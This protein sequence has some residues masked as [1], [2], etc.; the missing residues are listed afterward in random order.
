MRFR[1]DPLAA[2]G[3]SVVPPIAPVITGGGSSSSNGVQSVVA[4]TNV[5][6]DNTDPRNPV[7]SASG[8]S[9]GGDVTGPSG[10]TDNAIARFDG[11]TG[12]I[13]QNSATSIAD[14][15]GDITAGKYN[16]VAISGSST[17]TLAVTGTTAVSGTNT[18]DQ[19]SVTGNAGT[20]TALATGRTIRTDLASTSTATF[21]GTANIT[22]G[23]TG[24]LA[25]GNGGTGTTTLTG[26]VKGNG[27]SAFTA[28]VAG[29]DYQIPITLTTTGTSGAATFVAGTLN[30][31]QYTGGGGS[32]TVTSVDVSG[33]NGIGVSGNPITTS[34][35]IALSL[36]NITPTSV[37]TGAVTADGGDVLINQANGGYDFKVG[38]DSNDGMIWV[39]KFFNRVGF[40]I[41]GVSATVDSP[42]DVNL[43]ARFRTLVAIGDATPDASKILN[44]DSTITSTSSDK[45]GFNAI[46]RANPG[47]TNTNTIFGGFINGQTL[48]GNG[49]DLTNLRGFKA[50]AEG[51]GTGTITN[52]FAGEFMVNQT[53]A[54]TITNGYGVNIASASKGSGTITTNIGLNIADQTAGTTNYSIKTGVGKVY[55]GDVL[56]IPTG[57]SNGYVLTSDASG[58]ASWA[59]GGGGGSGITRTVVTTS[60]NYT[61]GSA[62]TTDYVYLIAGAHTT[63]LPTASGNSDR[64]TFKNNHSA[65]VTINRAGSDTIEGATSLTLGVGESVDLISNGST[66]WNVI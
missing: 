45:Y 18:G 65:N 38:G 6:V 32:G 64:Y 61:A 12:K 23:V 11:T 53:A 57:A 13:I 41:D 10:A 9:G 60:G 37:S 51:N 66:A 44:I 40:G 62:S 4:G 55:I 17:P 28:A 8:G 39:R 43:D 15:T 54:G 20:A 30:I 16:T 26:L 47:S 22:P 33:A 5:S 7:V 21:D 52:A 49:Q 50:I 59:A 56:Q 3:I 35:T 31:P 27:T 58:N 42:F 36:G 1:L 34:G 63:T 19:T 24:T 29:T 46:I 14:T 48:G 25:V 2:K